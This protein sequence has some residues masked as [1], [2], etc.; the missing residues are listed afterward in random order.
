ML[1]LWLLTLGA[2]WMGT[3]FL[4]NGAVS[5]FLARRTYSKPDFTGTTKDRFSAARDPA[6]IP[7]I[8]FFARPVR[9]ECVGD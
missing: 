7:S 4:K 3:D 2:F 5:S 1:V 8:G 6:G 9:G